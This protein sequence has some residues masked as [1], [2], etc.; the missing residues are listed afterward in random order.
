[1]ALYYGRSPNIKRT[2]SAIVYVLQIPRQSSGFL[3]ENKQIIPNL[4]GFLLSHGSRYNPGHV[5]NYYHRIK[6]WRP[7]EIDLQNMDLKV[8][9][10]P[11]GRILSPNF[12]R[13]SGN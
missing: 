6:I 5:I 11:D 13:K 4:F 7:V 12:K 9:E 2:G 10:I 8:S 3:N 1:M